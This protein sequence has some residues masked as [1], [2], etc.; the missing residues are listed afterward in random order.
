MV[1][2]G[3]LVDV[4]VLYLL[5]PQTERMISDDAVEYH[6]PTLHGKGIYYKVCSFHRVLNILS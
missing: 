5:V 3:W 1:D 2:W 4:C 6:L